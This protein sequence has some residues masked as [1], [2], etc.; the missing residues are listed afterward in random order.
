MARYKKLA[1]VLNKVDYKKSYKP[2]KKN[3]V[4]MFNILNHSIFSGKLEM[5]NIRIRK[6]RGALGE[7]CYDTENP[8]FSEIS[9]TTRY[10]NMQHFINV[11]AHEMVHQYQV[12]VQNDN[13]NHNRKFY[14]WKNK[15]A[16]MGLELG[17]TA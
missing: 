12:T 17:R 9:L 11:L 2:T 15:F 7:Y 10:H 6:L 13:G 5:P 16:K 4:M 14:R 1:T 8:D 3:T